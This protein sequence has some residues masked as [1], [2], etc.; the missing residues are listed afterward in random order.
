MSAGLVGSVE[1]ARTAAA[2]TTV[3]PK[4]CKEWK[5][6]P[7]VE[8]WTPENFAQEQ[9]RGL[10]RQIFFGNP[11]RAVRQVVFSAVEPETDVQG[12]CRS[13]GEALAEETAGSIAVVGNFPIPIE[14]SDQELVTQDNGR[15]GI[16]RLRQ[17]ATKVDENLWLVPVEGKQSVPAATLHQ[18]LSQ[19]RR[20]FEYSIVAGRAAGESN[21]A[22]AMAQFADGIILVLSAQHTRRATALRIKRALEGSRAR[23]MGTVLCD[24]GFPMPEALYRRL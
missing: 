16:K 5:R 11:E 14:S 8:G 15:D 23:L 20:E 18:Y 21:Q 7:R 9:I 12:L 4:V 2:R 19:V 24:R 22:L 17:S 10:V 13:V 1:V 3:V 6:A